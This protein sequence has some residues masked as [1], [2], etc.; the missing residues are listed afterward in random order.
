MLSPEAQRLT[1]AIEAYLPL[2]RSLSVVLTDNAY[3]MVTVRRL[4]GAYDVRLHRMFVDCPPDTVRALARYIVLNDAAAAG[5]LGAYVE[6]NQSRIKRLPAKVRQPKIRTRGAFHDLAAVYDRLNQ[7]FFD[8]RLEA[9]I[10]W[11]PNI[12]RKTPRKSMK[13]GSFSV[14]DRLI[15]IN[16]ALDRPFVPEFFVA[17]VVFHEMLHGKHGVTEA[18]GRR[19][20]HPPAFLEDERAYP[21]YDRARIWERSHMDLLLSA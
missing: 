13:M 16:P 14:E 20:F 10:T 9:R 3:T 15:R 19:C 11:G 21:D 18:G 6:A 2:G 5:L 8:G 12:R 4:A 1:V 7:E 17:W